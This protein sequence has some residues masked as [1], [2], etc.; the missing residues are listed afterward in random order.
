MSFAS[1]KKVLLILIFLHHFRLWVYPHKIERKINFP[2]LVQIQ[3]Q[4]FFEKTFSCRTEINLLKGSF[5]VQLSQR[6]NG[7]VFYCY[8]SH[9]LL[10]FKF[11]CDKGVKMKCAQCFRMQHHKVIMHQRFIRYSKRNL[12]IYQYLQCIFFYYNKYPIFF[13]I[14]FITRCLFSDFYMF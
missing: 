9:T 13:I 5:S 7:S 1:T 2:V 8:I 4:N 6:E 10:D 11:I 12:Q 14:L 3:K